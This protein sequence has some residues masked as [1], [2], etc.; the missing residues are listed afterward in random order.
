M[1]PKRLDRPFWTQRAT[2]GS[3]GEHNMSETN[4][5]VTSL[6]GSDVFRSTTPSPNGQDFYRNALKALN[7]LFDLSVTTAVGHVKQVTV[8]DTDRATAIVV[9]DD[10]DAKVANTVINTVTG[11]MNVT[12]TGEFA[13]NA[14]LMAMHKQ[15]LETACSIRSETIELLKKV[16]VD[17]EDLLNGK[18]GRPTP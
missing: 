3:A 1:L 4:A 5:S 7:E 16:I 9:M 2:A 6:T 17:F 14:D 18:I 12:Y 8:S 11:N 13:G 15:A 10:P